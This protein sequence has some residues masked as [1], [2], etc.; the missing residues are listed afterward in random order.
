MCAP[1]GLVEDDPLAAGVALPA[2]VQDIRVRIQLV[3]EQ[4]FP[5]EVLGIAAAEA[6]L[7]RFAEV[8]QLAVAQA[9]LAAV[10]AHGK[11]SPEGRVD[12]VRGQ[13]PKVAE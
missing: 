1:A 9:D 4:A 11:G 10:L 12:A 13:W 2:R 6:R 5:D 7:G 3:V 8:E